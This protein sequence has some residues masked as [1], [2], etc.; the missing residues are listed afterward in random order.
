MT[1]LRNLAILGG[2]AAL[3][4]GAV[5]YAAAGRYERVDATVVSIEELC[6]LNRLERD[7]AV[8]RATM[9]S[10]MRCG[11]ADALRSSRADLRDAA[12]NRA[13]YV[14]FRYV[15]PAD[16]RPYMGSFRQ[17]A[18]D[19]DGAA[20]RIGDRLPVLAHTGNPPLYKRPD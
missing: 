19:A 10:P 5:Q 16:G 11:D 9:T 4:W 12:L 13:T 7:G 15:S 1:L 8:N 2:L 6:S 18:G 14:T 3:A 17:E 20:V